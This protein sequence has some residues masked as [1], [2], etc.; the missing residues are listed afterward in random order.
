MPK[1]SKESVSITTESRDRKH[2][3]FELHVNAN[4]TWWA[5]LPDEIVHAFEQAAIEMDHK[6]V[7]G[8]RQ[9]P[10][11]TFIGKDR[12]TVIEKVKD[13]FTKLHETE[14]QSE[15]HVIKYR[16]IS[17]AQFKYIPGQDGMIAVIPD[18]RFAGDEYK[19]F[20]EGSGRTLKLELECWVVARTVFKRLDGELIHKDVTVMSTTMNEVPEEGTDEYLIQ[21][22]NGF[23]LEDSS[24]YS[25]NDAPEVPATREALLFFVGLIKAMCGV[26]FKMDSISKPD[27]LLAAIESDVKLLQ[28]G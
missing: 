1:V 27:D 28:H 17:D 26:A 22:I 8:Y 2:L 20:D 18:R 9:G 19:S 16:F 10:Q 25:R 15:Q 5:K 23:R 14:I 24:Y 6:P 3:N 13:A 21:W 12:T 4:G 7:R 11:I